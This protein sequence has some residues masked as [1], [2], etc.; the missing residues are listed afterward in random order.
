MM[1]GEGTPKL[2]EEPGVKPMWMYLSSS[3]PQP[4]DYAIAIP[5][6]ILTDLDGTEHTVHTGDAQVV[7][8]TP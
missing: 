7:T 8:I 6:A 4:G 2:G 1:G 5:V 3:A